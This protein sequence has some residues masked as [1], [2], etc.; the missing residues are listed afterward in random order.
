[1]EADERCVL[2]ARGEEAEA[3]LQF[4]VLAQLLAG[5]VLAGVPLPSR[6]ADAVHQTMT[7]AVIAYQQAAGLHERLAALH[8]LLGHPDRARQEWQRAAG[9]RARA[10]A[11]RAERDKDDLPQPCGTPDSA[12]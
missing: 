2:R 6:P 5:E 7:L 1:V 4:G 3:S 12:G 11:E 9:A 10:R 8:E